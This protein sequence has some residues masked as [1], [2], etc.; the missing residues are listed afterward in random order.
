MGTIGKIARRTFLI[1][2]GLVA[3]GLAVGYYWRPYPNPLDG[4]LVEGEATFNPYV[5]IALDNTITLIAPRA[6]MGQGVAT[7][8]AAL[9]AEELDVRLDQVLV[10]HGPAGHAYANT[11]MLEE[12]VPFPSFDE[13]TVAELMRA[14]MGVL[15]K[16]L[17]VQGTG[18][19]TSVIDGYYKMRQAGAAA[20]EVLKL[21]A[22]KRL[23]VEP[24]SLWTEGGVVT[25]PASGKV[26]TYGEL[27]QEAAAF[28]PPAEIRL[29]EKSE[30]KILGKPQKRIDMHVKVTG[31]PIYGIDVRLPDMLFATLRMNPYRGGAIVGFD[32][33]EAEKMPGVVKVL[34]VET[35]IANGFAVIADNTWRA[36]QAA[37]VV[38]VEWGK[39]SYPPD[40]DG[41][42]KVLEEALDGGD[43]SYGRN[44]GDVE[45]AFAD[46]PRERLIEADYS[47]PYLA[48]V[49]MEP[50]NA[51]AQ[52]M[53]GR[54]DIWAP[55][56]TPTLARQLAAA[57]VGIETENCFVHTTYLGGGFGRRVDVD[58]AIYAAI[59]AK[60]A[61]GRPVQVT[62]TRE[63]DIGQDMYRPAALGRF[64]ARI[65][66]DG[67]PVA[68]DMRIAAPSIMGSILPRYFP[69][70]SPIGP[71]KTITD[72]S[73]NQPY[74]L[75]NYRVGGIKAPVSIPVGF[76][77]SVG[78]SFN[79]FFHEGFMDEIAVAGKLDP[80]ELRRRLMADYPTAVN[81][82]DK[83]GTMSRWGETL[84]AGKAKGFAFTLSFGTWVAEVVQVA[85]VGGKI[86]IEKVWCA[87]DPGQVIDPSIFKAQMMSGIVYGL[88]SAVGE[89]ITFADGAAQQSNFHDYGPMRMDQCPEIEVGL[90]ETAHRMGGAGEPGTPPSIPALANA[91]YALTGKRI[92]SMP[93]S[94]EAEFV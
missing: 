31:A 29:R 37:A 87:A 42:R 66:E 21:A 50:M 8:L 26:F 3:G 60:E 44:D 1:G 13:S 85:D 45:T 43:I 92:R 27:A 30:W 40:S 88:S 69:R 89:E 54:L 76:W 20:R 18:G 86:R 65:G 64:R 47:V 22:A 32:A 56:Q 25:D 94:K 23:D 58:Y 67:L 80:L 5:K 71:D 46:A 81:V 41:I 72:G 39:G 38:K 93:L 53:G 34:K 28:A 55:N 83:V 79:G 2:T 62:W 51:T 73:A 61:D 91:V 84:P 63:E 4:E 7:T 24:G 68:V 82:I 77:R 10:E 48:H 74:S 90:L 14:G 33:A 19:S 6:E 70:L 16:F 11:A 49:T 36:F 59:V 12:G 35:G 52:L 15:G 57:V 17:G 9:V 75:A 78:N